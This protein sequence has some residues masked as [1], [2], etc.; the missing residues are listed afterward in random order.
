M[1]LASRFIKNSVSKEASVLKDSKFFNE[2]ELISTPVPAFNIA[3]SGSLTGGFGSGLTVWAGPSKHFKSNACLMM[4]SAYMNKFEDSV[5]LFYDSE[6]GSPSS[7]FESFGIDTERVAHIPVTNIEELK[8]DLMKQLEDIQR[9]DKVI[10]VV[11]SIGNLAS[12]KEVEDAKDEKSVADMTRAKALKGL[13]R[14]ITPL[15][16]LKDVP[17]LAINHVYK[18]Q[19]AMY[20]SDIVSGGTGIYLSATNIFIIGRQQEKEDKELVGYN[21]IINVEK[22]RYSREKSKIP[23]SV[24]F[25]GGIDKYSG[26]M[27]I[28]LESGHAVKPSNGWYSRKDEEKK[29]RLKETHCKE[30]WKG[31]LMDETFHEFIE[32]KYKLSSGKMMLSEE[33]E[34][35]LEDIDE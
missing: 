16:S 30:F 29:W 15:L 23:F 1:S 6:F 5:M 24:R 11:D 17:M 7:Y 28:A 3:L 32:K 13:F 9:T 18:E 2:Q 4:A 25:D 10:I 19:G 35:S 34:E 33:F 20:P 31:I 8:F 22:S 27:D 26:L 12:K 14:M 21:F